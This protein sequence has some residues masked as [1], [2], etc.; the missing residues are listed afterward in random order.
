MQVCINGR[1]KT[2]PLIH[3]EIPNSE[4]F[5]IR[6]SS[7]DLCRFKFEAKEAT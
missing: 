2:C 7:T 6:L 5:I 1:I 4:I 3:T